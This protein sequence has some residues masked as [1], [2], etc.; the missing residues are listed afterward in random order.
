M[1][2]MEQLADFLQDKKYTLDGIEG[3]FKARTYTTFYGH[4]SIRID[5]KPTSKGK[6]SEAYQE[7]KR[8]L[9]DDFDSDVTEDER[10]CDIATELGFVWKGDK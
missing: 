9:G 4:S 1:S 8:Q 7:I 2:I 10:L 5:H 3:I 6:K